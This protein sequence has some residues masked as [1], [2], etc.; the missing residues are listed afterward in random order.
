[1]NLPRITIVTVS[2]N[3][4]NIIE[5]TIKSIVEQNYHNLEYIIIDGNSVDNTVKLIR[6]YENVITCWKSEADNGIYDAMNKGIELATGDWISFMNCGDRFVNNTV[7]SDIFYGQ[8][9]EEISVIYG[10]TILR[11]D[12]SYLLKK[13]NSFNNVFPLL[14]HQSSFTRTNLLKKYSFNLD[15]KITADID[16]FFKIFKM[17]YKFHYIPIRISV[18]NISEGLST[19]NS[20]LLYN[21][22]SRIFSSSMRYNI[23]KSSFVSIL[24]K[25]LPFYIYRKIRLALLLRNSC[26]TKI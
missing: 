24:N 13:A 12:S 9:D 10:D 16:F 25:I 22:Y 14:C 3:A 20:L 23:I 5:D 15:Y 2:Y 4:E 19:N 6:K 18:Y 17:G 1:M 7:L 26:I 8:I 21:E 11:F